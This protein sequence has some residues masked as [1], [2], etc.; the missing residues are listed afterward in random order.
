MNIL[1]VGAGIF[2]FRTAGEK[3]FLL[4]LMPRLLQEE[5][6]VSVFS[7]NDAP[8]RQHLFRT[9]AG[10]VTIHCQRRPFHRNLDRFFFDAPHGRSYHHRHGPLWESVERTVALL[11]SLPRLRRVVR[12]K[13]IDV[14][15]FSDNFGPLMSVAG[16]AAGAKGTT[17]TAANYN[18]RRAQRRYDSYLRWSMNGLTGVGVFTQA[19]QTILRRLGVRVPLLPL[20]WGVPPVDPSCVD[21]KRAAGRTA[22]LEGPG[23]LFVWCGFLQQTGERELYTAAR[24]FDQAVRYVPTA[25]LVI[26]LKPESFRESYL[27]L[28]RPHTRVVTGVADILAL[29]AGADFLLSPILDRSSTVSPPLT[30]LESLSVGTPIVTTRAG[31]TDELFA[32]SSA[33][34]IANDEGELP[35]T[36]V[37]AARSSAPSNLREAALRHFSRRFTLTHAMQSHVD[38]WRFAAGA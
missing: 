19:Y 4:S 36:I 34:L 26:A 32:G 23:P 18:P 24:A 30:W 6:N 37:Q 2:A 12:E 8:E 10:D 3:N 35:D 27:A 17:F 28:A 11:W 31:G 25:R 22:W 33:V 20:T 7:L 13:A 9:A 38:L 5:V 16:S 29:L 14:V 21:K 15:H 1:I